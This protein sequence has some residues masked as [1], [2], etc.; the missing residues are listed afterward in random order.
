MA[1]SRRRLSLVAVA[2]ATAAGALALGP[3]TA[4]AASANQ[5]G[6]AESSNEEHH[7]V[8]K[9]LRDTASKPWNNERWVREHP[10]ISPAGATTPRPDG[11]LQ[12][13]VAANSDTATVGLGFAGVGQGDYAYMV[14]AAPP[15]TTGA[16]GDTQ[17]VQWVNESFAVFDKAT[18]AIVAGFPKRGNTLWAGFGGG[19]EKNNDGDPVVQYDKAASRWVLTQF[20]VT[21]PSL[22]GYLQCVAVSQTSD[23][24]GAYNRY[25]FSYGKTAFNDYPK[26]GVWPD[27]Y[28]ISYN[29]FNNGSTFAGSKVCALDRAKML[30]G[31]AA[32]QQ[33]FQ[34][35]TAY[36]SLVPTDLDGATKPSPGAPNVFAAFGANRLDIWKFH[37]DFQTPANAWFTG[38]V[39]LSV[40]P[41]AEA[42][43]AG[44]C[45]PQPGTTQ[46]LDSL[47]DRLMYRLVYRNFGD[48]ESWVVTHS[49]TAGSSVGV[50]WYEL[51][52]LAGTPS[53]TQQ[54]TYA[55]DGDYR[56]MG[57]AAMDKNG[58]IAVGYSLSGPSRNP[59]VAYATRLPGDPT[60]TLGAETVARIGGGA[61]QTGLGRWGDYST[62]TVDPVDD[63][64]FWYS[65]EYLKANGTFNWSTWITSFRLP[66]CT[67]SPPPPPPSPPPTP[68]APTALTA[69]AGPGSVALA[70]TA[71]TAGPVTSYSLQRTT[72]GP[73][74]VVIPGITGTTYT[75]SGLTSGVA[76]TYT[77]T[78]HNAGGP[79][80]ASNAVTATPTAVAPVARFTQSC[81]GATCTFNASTSTGANAYGWA[82]GDG[83]T[84]SGLTPSHSYVRASTFTVRLTAS[85]GGSSSQATSTVT[86]T[87]R[88]KRLSCR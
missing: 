57:S 34:T 65:S 74:T 59:S 25:S 72:S 5:N 33:C 11:A 28:Y 68:G 21:N 13:Q 1:I 41:F 8:S 29:I 27:G 37:A 78:A 60:G 79:G 2:L 84:G 38:P 80:P 9:R 43:A 67:S 76:Y 48:H 86:C 45:I 52:G 15:D 46:K 26:L 3:V 19:C 85:S 71:P 4:S 55:P 63:C 69:T 30:V 31:A 7:D 61:Q 53:V 58:D 42:C 66:S 40:A 51:T 50:R 20:S 77:V 23:A 14:D 75:D 6:T 88:T 62:M 22:Y 44:S 16:V 87:G 18:G 24:T 54:G 47:A 10:T 70:W 32:T 36:G 12:A 81:S 39:P 17:Y 56:W 73:T 83:A 35:S 82:F 64:T 49:V